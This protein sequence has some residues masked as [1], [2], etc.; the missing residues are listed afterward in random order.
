MVAAVKLASGQVE[1]EASGNVTQ[2][3]LR[4]I[5]DTGVDYISIGALTKDCKALDL[6]MRLL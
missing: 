2:N 1:L 3:T 5:A 4:P 6:S